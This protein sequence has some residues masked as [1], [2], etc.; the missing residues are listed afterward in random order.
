MKL[1]VCILSLLSLSRMWVRQKLY[2]SD[3]SVLRPYFPG[4]ENPI[5]AYFTGTDSPHRKVAVQIMDEQGRLKGFAKISRNFQVSSLLVHEATILQQ[6]R[7]LDLQSAH[8]PQVLF[9]GQHGETTLLVTDTLKTATT[10]SSTRFTKVHRAFLQEIARKTAQPAQS[11]AAV[12]IRFLA[13]IEAL[14]QQLNPAWYQRLNE[15]TA[16]LAA[17]GD[18][19]IPLSLSHGDFTPWNTFFAKGA[20][21]VFDWEYAEESAPPSNDIIHFALNEPQLRNRPSNEKLTA[22]LTRLGEN[23]TG[24]AQRTLPALLIIYLLTQVLRQIERLP[25]D[26]QQEGNWDAGADHAEMLDILLD[27]KTGTQP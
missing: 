14:R 10:R 4:L 15:A 8:I 13:R 9:A 2:V 11:A 1:G 3:E 19:Q 22:V 23:W 7:A 16:V 17:Q 27:Y 12:G 24:L 25:A 20:L 5:Y 26:L 21:Y 18:L 6:M